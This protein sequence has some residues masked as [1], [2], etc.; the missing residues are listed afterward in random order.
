MSVQFL[1]PWALLALLF[2]P[3]FFVV[4]WPRLRRLPAWMRRSAMGLRLLIVTLFVLSLAQPLLGRASDDVSVV[5]ALDHSASVSPET[6]AQAEAFIQQALAQVDEKHRAGLVVFGQESI[7]RRS[8]DGAQVTAPTLEPEGSA[9]NLADAL[10]LSR[11]L[12]PLRGGRRVVLMSDGRQNVGLADEEARLAASSNVQV[13]VVPLGP[14]NRPEVLIENLDVAPQIREGDTLDIRMSVQSTVET[15]ATIRLWMDQR[16]ISEQPINLKV[17]ANPFNASQSG[18]KKGFHSF[19]ARVETAT[20]TFSENNEV[21][22]FTVVKDRPR[23]LLIAVNEA[24]GRDLR[25]ALAAND[26]QV[27]LRPP[28]VIPPRLSLMKRIDSVVLINVPASAMTLDQMKTLQG[29]VQTLGGGLTVVGGEQAYSLGDYAKTPLADILPVNMNVPGKR[30]RGSVAMVLVVD[31]SGSMD[32]RDNAV[33][34]MQM[35]REAAAMA[36]DS[37]D[38]ADFVGVVTFDTTPRWHVPV[39]QVSNGVAEIK[40]RIGS[41]EASG[42]TEIYPALDLAHKAIR[43]TRAQYRHVILLSDGRSLSNADYDRL[44]AQMRADGI[45]LSTIAIGSDA[46][47]ALLDSLAKQGEGRYYYVDK[48]VDIPKVTTREAKIASGSPIVEGQAK[49]VFTSPSPIIRNIAEAS[50]PI[51]TGYNVVT[52]KETAQVVMIPDKER[53]D[54]LLAQWQF[55]LG[56]SVAWTSDSK[57]KWTS[58]WLA[59]ADY[60]RFWGQLVRWTMPA[61]SD[62]NLQTVAVVDGTNVTVRVEALDDDGGFRDLQDIRVTVLGPTL[63]LTDQ[64]ARQVA[65]GRYELSFEAADI[66]AYSIDATQLEN[67]KPVRTEST[68]F[69]ISYPAEYRFLGSDD[70]VLNRIAAMTGGKILRDPRGVFS[71]DGLKFQGDTWVALW[72]WLLA[73]ALV[74]FPLDIAFRRLQVPTELAFRWLRRG[75]FRIRRGG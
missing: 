40:Q 16:L 67:G 30:D 13:S 19:W 11:S 18:L 23:V 38:P 4:G 36:M 20:D 2:L 49:P 9:T 69:A 60:R 71:P 26:I 55:G 32:M 41:I 68:G 57:N 52:A 29:Y 42:G 53:S 7:V 15:N 56:R 8:I 22:A 48:A 65:P 14:G 17:G 35:A 6:R 73:A 5:F 59:W 10:R 63:Q 44:V 27:D 46:D 37:L 72:P 21:A 28:S 25:D 47:Q 51:V 24:D 61:P 1:N 50:I 31:K 12:L 58:E 3:F 66:G 64:P 34:K 43:E 45:T 70:S 74:L 75:L 62:P 39:R 54:P 33:T